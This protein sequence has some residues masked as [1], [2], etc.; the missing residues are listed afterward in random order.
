MSEKVI[1]LSQKGFLSRVGCYEHNFVLQMSLDD[2]QRA[3]RQCMVAW[4]DNSNA[5]GSKPHHHIFDTF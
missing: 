4:L 1:S 2:A 3:R 5:F